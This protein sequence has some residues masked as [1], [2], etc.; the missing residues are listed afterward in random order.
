MLV[1]QAVVWMPTIHCDACG[2]EVATRD[3]I[4]H[5]KGHDFQYQLAFFC[6]VRCMSLGGNMDVVEKDPQITTLN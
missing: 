1:S 6:S 3:S 5:V 4:P 2:A